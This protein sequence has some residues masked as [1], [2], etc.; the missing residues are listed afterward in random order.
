MRSVLLAAALAASLAAAEGPNLLANPGMTEGDSAP[1]GWTKAW[2]ATGTVAAVRD[3]AVFK[4]GP[5]ALRVESVGGTAKG[6]IT[7]RLTGL[8]GKS[9]HITGWVRGDGKAGL[10]LG[11]GAFDANWKML[12][13]FVVHS[14]PT[15]APEEWVAVDKTVEIPA[16]TANVNFSTGL[17][18]DGKA[19][20]DDLSATVP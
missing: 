17:V 6:S 7:Q 14:V 3:T 11:V 2:A 1:T 18:G 20:F 4:T 8:D 9:L 10:N 16:G 12:Q 15:A 13:W 19:W 5:A